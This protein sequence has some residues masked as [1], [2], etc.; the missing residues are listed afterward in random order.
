MSQSEQQEQPLVPLLPPNQVIPAFALPG[1]DG[2][3]HS[4]WEYK[5]RENLA[6]VF[7]RSSTYSETRGILRT[8]AYHYVDFREE[9]CAILAVTPDTVIVNLQSQHDL[10]VPFALLADPRAEVISRYTAWDS[11]TRS[12]TP[13][14]VLTNRYGA[15]YQ[16][17]FAENEAAL[18][19]ISE[20]LAA[21]QY[22][23][24]ICTP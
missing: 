18:P 5:Q 14:I 19:P 20:L 2:T 9:L 3:P 7:T 24:S 12:L 13:C 17:W 6:I 21:L 15:L 16:Q 8:F 4:P 10:H 11:K 22:L 23:N 1:A